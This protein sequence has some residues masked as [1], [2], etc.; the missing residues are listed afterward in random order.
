MNERQCGPSAQDP[1]NLIPV[2]VVLST[3]PSRPPLPEPSTLSESCT[4][5]PG[6]LSRVSVLL[7][8]RCLEQFLRI[9]L[10]CPGQSPD[11]K[12]VAWAVPSEEQRQSYVQTGPQFIASDTTH[13]MLRLLSLTTN[14]PLVVRS[15]V[16]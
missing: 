10:K 13:R 4:D 7:R 5:R 1:K 9:H 2:S 12:N 16:R 15:G 8:L 11:I 14:F 3:H 6:P